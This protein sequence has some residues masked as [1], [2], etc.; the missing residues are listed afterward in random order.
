MEDTSVG[1]APVD[2]ADGDSVGDVVDGCV[3]L[4]PVL[5]S[6][7]SGSVG[8]GLVVSGGVVGSVVSG[9]VVSGAVVSGAVVSGAVESG[10]GL[11]AVSESGDV[12]GRSGSDSSSAVDP[13]VGT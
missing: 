3:G 12:N 5:G 13:G 10:S 11:G 4:T 7:V 6:V 2:D 9:A 8:A 1:Y